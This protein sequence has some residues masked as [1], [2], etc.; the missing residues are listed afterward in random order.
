MR[1]TGFL[2]RL[3]IPKAC[4]MVKKGN[5]KG[6]FFF[7]FLQKDVAACYAFLIPFR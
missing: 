6:I 3:L 7:F 5:D 2:T 4:K 1:N